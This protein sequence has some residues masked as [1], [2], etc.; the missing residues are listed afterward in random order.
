MRL[1][2]VFIFCVF[3]SF[4]LAQH[5]ELHPCGSPSYKTE[6]LKK[7]QLNPNQYQT[8]AGVVLYVPMT[9]H[10]VRRD[11]GSTDVTEEL[12]LDAFCTLN[13]DM[14]PAE[15]EF[16]IDDILYID[17]SDY[18]RHDTVLEGA[19]MMFANN[20][21]NTMNTY[22][23]SDPAGNCGYNL[24][25]AGIAM[26][27]TC[28]APE[29]HTWAHEVGHNL[30]L[31]HPFLGWEGGVSFDGSVSH[32]F[33]QPAPERVLYDYTFFQDTLILDTMI[34]DTAFV[35]K[36]DGS[37]CSF[38]ADGFC[39]TPPDYLA[40]RWQC[41]A[42]SLSGSEMTDPNG[43]VFR[44]DGQF[45]MSYSLDECASTFSAEQMA[46]MRANLMDEKPE[47]LSNQT[48]P[49]IMIAENLNRLYPVED[50]IV[51]FG[52]VRLE[53]EALEGADMYI[54][55]V[56]RFGNGALVEFEG[57]TTNS[58]IDVPDLEEEQ[59]YY[60]RM[61][62]VNFY[63]SCGS[64]GE[65]I[66]FTTSNLSAVT[67]LEDDAYFIRPTLLESGQVINISIFNGVQTSLELLNI[68]GKVVHQSEIGSN[69]Q[70]STDNINSGTYIIRIIQNGT[71]AT[72]KI[73]IF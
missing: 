34:I 25:Y 13:N 23:V 42:N 11:N 28:S 31:P 73:S 58:F 47:L 30:S 67:E 33:T 27:N 8:K 70:L 21:P 16:Y 54:V 39:D 5:A 22:F 59:D 55:E 40:F 45:I 37:N 41:I 9:I 7:Y 72:K 35:E 3:S 66:K 56:S 48:A 71:V 1:S 26:N 53:W 60:W 52:D 68:S 15:I 29:D 64:Y 51:P 18:Y 63:N 12:V 4:V 2:I 14:A 20:V 32:D 61:R 49:V 38:A 46:A 62:P 57:S 69:Y 6:W 24:P 50:E 17:N 10:I 43:E 19:D 36:M 65:D 44:S